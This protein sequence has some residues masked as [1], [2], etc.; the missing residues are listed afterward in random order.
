MLTNQLVSIS[1]AAAL[2]FGQV[3]PSLVPPQPAAQV[4]A[5]HEI[6]LENRYPLKSVSE[7]FKDNILLNLAYMQGKVTSKN[8]LNWDEVKRPFHYELSLNPGEV[9]AFHDDVLDTYK[10]KKGKT[11]QAHFTADEGFKSDGYLF[12]DGVCQLASLIYW[13]AKDAGL[14]SL[15]PTNHNFMTIPEISSEYGVSIYANPYSGSSNASQNLYIT[16]N[17]VIPIT[18]LF[19]YANDKL[20]VSV[21]ELN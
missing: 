3:V 14:D 20:K 11:T 21:A 16:N 15:A 5:S 17:R 10:G 19:D 2:T 4:V 1:A 7:I 13:V 18:F 9:F 8:N 12:G 6:S